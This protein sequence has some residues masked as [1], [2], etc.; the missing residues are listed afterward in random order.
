[1]S[2][3]IE[4][5]GER[6]RHQ[7]ERKGRP[8]ASWSLMAFIELEWREREEETEA[9]ISINSV[10]KWTAQ[11]RASV[12]EHGVFL[13]SSVGC[14]GRATD[15]AGSSAWVAWG[16]GLARMASR[17]LEAGGI[18]AQ[19]CG[20]PGAP[21]GPSGGCR[22]VRQGRCT[23]WPRCWGASSAGRGGVGV[24]GRRRVAAA[25]KEQGRRN[26]VREWPACL[27]GLIGPVR[28]GFCVCFFSFFSIPFS[29]F[30]IHYLITIKLIILKQKLFINKILI[31]GLIIII[32]V[33]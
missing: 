32:L 31:F 30:K 33:M 1:V 24:A 26:R 13:W 16:S 6:K 10:K 14:R 21:S 3:F 28:L 2:D 19:S 15:W 7:R 18:L 5:K 20:L 4:E 23:G 27:M 11:G 29:K 25:T 9:L 17:R 8:G 22:G 12:L